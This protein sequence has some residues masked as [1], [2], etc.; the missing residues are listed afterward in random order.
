MPEAIIGRT[1]TITENNAAV[2]LGAKPGT[3]QVMVGDYGWDSGDFYVEAPK[4]FK[5]RELKQ[6]E[7]E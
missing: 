5:V 2:L 4:K 7:A 3:Y 1:Y 6:M